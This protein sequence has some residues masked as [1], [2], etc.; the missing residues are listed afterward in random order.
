LPFGARQVNVSSLHVVL[1]NRIYSGEFDWKGVRYQGSYDPLVTKETWEKVQDL[2]DLR[3]ESRHRKVVHDFLFSGLVRCGHCRCAL[4]AE[5]KKR[6]YVY[7]HCTGYKG[8]CDEPYTREEVLERQFVA[9]LKSLVIPESVLAWLDQ[10]LTFSIEQDERIRQRTVKSWQDEWDRLQARLDAM[11]EDKLDG[12]ITPEQFD[13]KAKDTRSKQQTLRAKISEH[14]TSGT[15]LRAGFNMMRLTSIACRE[16]ERQNA[17]E[18]RKLLELV[19][20]GAVWKDGRLEVTLHEPFRTLALSNSAS[21]RKEG[22][23]ATSSAEF[24]KWLPGMDSN[25]NKPKQCGICKLQIPKR[26][27]LPNW[28]RKTAIGTTLVQ[29]AKASVVQPNAHGRTH[30]LAPSSQRRAVDPGQ[31]HRYR[32]C[33]VHFLQ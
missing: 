29:P 4:V 13:R 15:D 2:L 23:E 31:T 30:H 20:E 12:R 22:A 27:R 7:Y 24:E 17:R 21:A 33:A 5:L 32:C 11:Y 6:R 18:R 16:F 3:M 28:A 26:S 1:R 9:V 8:K 14:Q 25:H 19:V 10:E